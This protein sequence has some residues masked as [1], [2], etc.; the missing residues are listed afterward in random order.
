MG[1]KNGLTSDFNT[2]LKSDPIIEIDFSHF[3]A[4]Y[5]KRTDIFSQ[6]NS[7]FALRRS[8]LR[9][10]KT[11]KEPFY[12]PFFHFVYIGKVFWQPM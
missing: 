6:Y 4:K 12:F 10:D 8:E 9:T 11:F 1:I 7:S 3:A 5:S 2:K